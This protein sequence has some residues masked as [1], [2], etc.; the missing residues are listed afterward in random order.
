MARKRHMTLA[1]SPADPFQERHGLALHDRM[2]LLGGEFHFE[3]DSPQLLRIVRLAY[4]GLPPHRLSK[5]APRCLVRLALTS[6]ARTGPSKKRAT[7][8]PQVRP[9]AGGGIFCGA[10]ESA[11]FA[12]VTPQQRSALI[13]VSRDMLIFSYHIRISKVGFGHAPDSTDRKYNLL[14][15]L[16]NQH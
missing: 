9:I 11:N 3:T 8:P 5:T 13:V 4:A 15:R 10:M 14:C 6:P 2:Q 12:A 1:E 16:K 7:E